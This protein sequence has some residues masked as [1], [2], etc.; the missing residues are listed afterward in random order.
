MNQI[1]S[2]LNTYPRNKLIIL[3][4]YHEHDFVFTDIGYELSKAIADH[5]SHKQIGLFSFDALERIVQDNVKIHPLI[6]SY[7]AIKNLGIFFEKELKINI[8]SFLNAYSQNHTLIVQWPGETE[9]SKLYFLSK[10]AGKIIHLKDISH[11]IV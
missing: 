1:L 8:L 2:F 9:P 5:L 10:N 6:G 3:S 7:I 11:I 4:S